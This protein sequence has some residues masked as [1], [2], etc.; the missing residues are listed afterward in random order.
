VAIALAMLYSLIG[1]SAFAGLVAIA[2]A[3][4]IELPLWRVSLR[5]RQPEV[6]PG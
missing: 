1:L 5:V 6:V 3:Y 4:L 2:L